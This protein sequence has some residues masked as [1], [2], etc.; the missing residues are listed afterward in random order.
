MTDGKPVYLPRHLADRR[1]RSRR[2]SLDAVQSE[3]FRKSYG[4]VFDGDDRWNE[5]EVPDRRL[6]SPGTTVDLRAR[7]AVLRGPDRAS[8]R[9]WSDIEGARVLAMLG[10]TVTTDHISPAGSIK[11][12][13]PAGQYLIEHGV[14]PRDFNSYGSRRGNHE[15]MMRGTFANIRLRNQLAPGT[16]GGVHRC[17]CPTAS[18]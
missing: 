1:P 17:T 10:D 16:E 15:V 14:Q 6:L 9:R 5:L 3:M 2:R 11:R 4:E 12:D 7:A 18:R 13:S 8:Q